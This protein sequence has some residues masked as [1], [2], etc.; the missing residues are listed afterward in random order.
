MDLAKKD[1][2]PDFNLQYMWQRTDP[3]QFRAYYS[4]TLG[5]R[6]SDLSRT[7]PAA[8]TSSSRSGSEPGEKRVR[9]PD[10]ANRFPASTA[11]L[12]RGEIGR[13][14]QDLPRRVNA[15]SARRTA[16]RYGCLPIQSPGFSGVARILPRRTQVRRGVLADT[17]GT[18]DGIG[19]NRRNHRIVAALSDAAREQDHEELSKAIRPCTDRKHCLHR[20]AGGIWWT[21]RRSATTQTPASSAPNLAAQPA[22]SNSSG[23]GTA[24]DG[25]SSRSRPALRRTIAIH[26]RQVWTG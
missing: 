18:R 25:D 17:F 2:Y 3:T 9:D 6:Y 20:R 13:T 4:V 12:E 11:I 19:T 23:F 1:F 7:P 22:Q 14:A 10:T 26:R 24:A 8:R 15:S 21:A 16:S 5:V